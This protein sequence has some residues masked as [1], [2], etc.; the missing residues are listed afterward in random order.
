MLSETH[1]VLDFTGGADADRTRDLLNAISTERCSP[2]SE[3]SN[4]VHYSVHGCS[5]SPPAFIAVGFTV[6]FNYRKYLSN[7]ASVLCMQS[8]KQQSLP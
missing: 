3:L 7:L 6:G 5:Y 4:T 2:V 1:K 8:D